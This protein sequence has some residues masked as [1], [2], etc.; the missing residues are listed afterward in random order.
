MFL[1]PFEIS[2]QSLVADIVAR[3][4]RTAD[5]FR[6]YGIGYCC[7]GKWP[8]EIACEMNGVNIDDLHI[9]IGINCTYQQYL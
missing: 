8:M 6:K 5:I 3:D 9:R 1:Q 7:G 4:Y 2:R